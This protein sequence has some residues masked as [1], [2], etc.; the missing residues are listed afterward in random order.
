MRKK[1]LITFTAAAV[2]IAAAAVYLYSNSTVIYNESGQHKRVLSFNAEKYTN[3]GWYTA[4]V[5]TMYATDGRT[6][7]IY[8]NETADYE[9]VGWYT[10][11]VTL[12]YAPEDVTIY[13]KQSEISN[14]E[15]AGY[16]TEPILAMYD[17][18]GNAIY[19][20][21]SEIEAYKADGY[22]TEPPTREGLYNLREQITTYLASRSGDWGVFVKSMKT[23]EYLSVNEKQYSGASLIKLFT[24]AAVYSEI[25][26]GNLTLN[27]DI[28]SQLNLMICESSNTACNY[29]TKKLGGGNTITGF[30]TEN[31]N[32][33]QLGCENT[34]HGSELVDESGRKVTFVG[35]NRTSPKDCCTILE[36]IYKGTLVSETASAGML[37]L[38][39]HQTRTWKIPAS[40]PEGTV[41]ANKTG[42]TD[43]AEGDAAIVYSP[44]C[45]YVICVIG[46]GSVGSGVD[47]IQTVSK[48]A[49]NYF[50]N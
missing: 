18:S 50:N 49:Y 36:N 3:N 23:N 5:R 22:L 34:T 8:E 46:N 26:K 43:T 28:K 24:M 41:V 21:Q 45:D 29:L 42:E 20:K 19:I 4:P 1:L 39:L 25:E 47:T 9:N 2:C 6:L 15:S 14:Y 31:N 37:D 11:P 38:L 48:M 10:E 40:L 13:V 33:K 27:D 30:N 16:S 44:A 32:T 17:A 12:M 35:F 7:C